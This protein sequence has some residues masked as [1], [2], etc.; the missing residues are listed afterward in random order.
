MLIG[1]FVVEDIFH[2][3]IQLYSLP[4]SLSSPSTT[5]P[6]SKKLSKYSPMR[7]AISEL[8]DAISPFSFMLFG[9]FFLLFLFYIYLKSFLVDDFISHDEK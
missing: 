3:Y 6:G 1:Q 5:D 7:F 9:Y 2:K 4:T 8:E